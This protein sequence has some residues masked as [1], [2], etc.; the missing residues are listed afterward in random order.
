M[1]TQATRDGPVTPVL[2]TVH[3]QANPDRPLTP[4]PR[5]MD[6][7]V[8]QDIRLLGPPGLWI[9]EPTASLSLFGFR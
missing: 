1:D 8:I 9:P 2:Q 5:P 6:R 3:T 4:V 7:Q